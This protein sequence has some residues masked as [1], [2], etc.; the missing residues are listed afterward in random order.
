MNSWIKI[1]TNQSSI[2]ISLRITH[3]GGEPYETITRNISYALDEALDM[4]WKLEL[5]GKDGQATIDPLS[6]FC[7][8][9]A[10]DV[11]GLYGW[12]YQTA[13]RIKPFL[14]YGKHDRL[15]A[16]AALV[17]YYL[18]SRGYQIGKWS[19]HGSQIVLVEEQQPKKTLR[20][21]IAEGEKYHWQNEDGP[22]EGIGNKESSSMWKPE[23]LEAE[24]LQLGIKTI[25]VET[26]EG[27]KL[28]FERIQ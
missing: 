21:W 6:C 4:V 28:R 15:C 20:Q 23:V 5:P 27:G 8:S 2:E 16:V 25:Q 3:T 22:G 1:L 17:A 13:I 18:T 10:D 12:T 26:P 19:N 11:R 9:P 14:S 24:I 7:A